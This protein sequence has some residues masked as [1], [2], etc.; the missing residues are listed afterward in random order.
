[1]IV[2]SLAPKK[3]V[4][5]FN[6]NYE[7]VQGDNYFFAI[8]PNEFDDF[9][10]FSYVNGL[11][12]SQGGVHVNYITDEVVNRLRAS[13]SKK[14]KEIKPGDIR[15]KLMIV[16]VLRDFK[17]LKFD[18]QT[19]EK[20]TNSITEVKQYFGDIDFDSLS[21]K[22]LKNS[23]LI[24]PIT[25]VYKIKE[26]FKLRQ[27]LKGLEKP[28]KKKPKDEK[29][30]TPIGDW[31]RLY[32]AEG[33]SAQG[34]LSKIIGRQGNGFYAMFGVP[35]N[36]YD[37]S[38]K[39]ILSSDKLKAL[40]QIIGLKYSQDT[41]DN[42]NFNEIII[43]TDADLPGFFIRGQLLGLFS[44]FAKN[45]FEEKRIKI[46]R[47]PIIV[48]YDKKENIVEW[49]YDAEELQQYE[50]KNPNSK[51]FFEWKKGLASWDQKELQYV[52]QKEGLDNMLE[53]MVYD[54]EA[55]ENLNNWLNGNLAD[56]RKE[57]LD[58]FEFSIV[59]L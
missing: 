44:R 14:Y 12:I 41:Q 29:L 15:N 34:S 21:K 7:I 9:R 38:M 42:I 52:I 18:S 24:D 6:E 22:I 40:Q 11:N 35:P 50:I 27:E 17:N 1:M 5:M 53:T 54:E 23:A 43:A 47:T 55:D 2:K 37:M 19:K 39:E 16:S 57:M 30:L 51:L 10:Q 33:D 32:L 46:L 58:G 36:A 20:V 26:E 8:M 45:L 4:E 28:E 13:L 56:K 48:G 3:Y 25:E 49:F 31:N 59:N